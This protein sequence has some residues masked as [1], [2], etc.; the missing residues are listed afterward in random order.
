MIEYATPPEYVW[1]TI[2]SFV[3][4][5]NINFSRRGKIRIQGE[6]Y[7]EWSP[8]F[9]EAFDAEREREAVWRGLSDRD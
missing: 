2:F 4:H 9:Q 1:V 8:E 7:Q 6:I 5:N 3:Q